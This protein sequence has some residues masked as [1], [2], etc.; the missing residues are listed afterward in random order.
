MHVKYRL[1]TV[2]IRYKLFLRIK[3]MVAMNLIIIGEIAAISSKL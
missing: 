2:G 1:I 3:I